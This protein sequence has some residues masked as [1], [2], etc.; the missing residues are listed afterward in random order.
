MSIQKIPSISNQNIKVKPEVINALRKI[1][2]KVTLGKLLQTIRL[3]VGKSQERFAKELGI[4]RT[5]LR[6]LEKGERFGSYPLAARLVPVLGIPLQILVKLVKKRTRKTKA[7]DINKVHCKRCGKS[8]FEVTFPRT[9][10][11]KLATYCY[12][13]SYIISKKR[14][15]KYKRLNKL[16]SKPGCSNI[17]EYRSR[18]GEWLCVLHHSRRQ[19]NTRKTNGRLCSIPGCLRS[20]EAKKLCERHY[21]RFLAKGDPLAPKKVY[22]G[23]IISRAGYIK[24]RTSLKQKNGNYYYIP[25]HRLVM[26]K[27]LGRPLLSTEN[28]HHKDGNRQNNSLDNLELWVKHRLSGQRIIDKVEAA[29]KIQ[30]TYD[31]IQKINSEK[32]VFHS[33]NKFKNFRKDL[34]INHDF[35]INEHGLQIFLKTPLNKYWDALSHNS[36]SIST[37]SQTLNISQRAVRKVL[38]RH[39]EL[40]EQIPLLNKENLKNSFWKIKLGAI[41]PSYPLKGNIDIDGYHKFKINKR[42]YLEHRLIMEIYLGRKLLRHENVHHKNGDRADNRIENLELWSTMQPQGQRIEDLLIWAHEI[43]QIY[44]QLPSILQDNEQAPQ[45]AV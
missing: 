24:L 20:V 4:S 26:E 31:K 22:K 9:I 10:Y 38:T 44:G 8:P 13:C 7:Q 21:Q 34:I 23:V 2:G 3:N 19:K 11:G 42:Q 12:P 1:Q 28:V 41:K 43:L 29:L 40:F 16:C 45:L 14:R 36:M 33:K 32:S 30:K 15:K 35:V 27:A 37:L 25:E 17:A 6:A 39:T 18:S 5:Q